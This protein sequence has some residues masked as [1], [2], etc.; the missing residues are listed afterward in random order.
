MEV[1]TLATSRLNDCG[2][3]ASHDSFESAE[4]TAPAT[5]QLSTPATT[6]GARVSSES[7]VL[8]YTTQ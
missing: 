7:V 8:P 1:W 2:E 4:Q 3:H 5:P 6:E